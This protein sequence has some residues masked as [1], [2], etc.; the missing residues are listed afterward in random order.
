MKKIYGLIGH[1]V[2]HSLSAL[3]HN[4]AFSALGIAAEYRLFDVPAH[5]VED[6]LKKITMAESE[7]F[8]L[9]VTI[10]HKVL[11]HNYLKDSLSKEAKMIGAVNTVCVIEEG[12]EKKL[13]GYNTD[14]EGFLRALKEDLKFEAQDKMVFVLG[15]GGAARA[16]IMALGELPEK[17]F[18]TDLDR[19]KAILLEK[20][21]QKYYSAR[22]IQRIE[23]EDKSDC[24]LISDIFINATDTGMQPEDALPIEERCLHK[25]MYIFDLIY[26]PKETKLI[27]LAREKGLPC[28]NGL[29][30]LLYQ[31]AASFRL[32]TGKEPPIELMRR[33]L[34]EAL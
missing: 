28:I 19:Q 30:M 25:N 17:I 23:I 21:Y 7:I 24:I 12:A 1:P 11:V 20:D 29:S 5:G 14:G 26:N 2:K 27:K 18:F 3:M 16:V 6:L 13:K 32:W 10:P 9:N 4:A 15:A 8:G 34:D 33:T 31:G 22:H